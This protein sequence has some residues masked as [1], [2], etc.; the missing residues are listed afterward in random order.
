MARKVARAVLPLVVLAWATLVVL[1]G[2]LK[3]VDHGVATGEDPAAMTGIGL[4]AIVVALLLRTGVGPLRGAPRSSTE[5]AWRPGVLRPMR[6]AAYE[7]PPTAAPSP[8]LLQV[9][10]T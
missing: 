5:H 8:A 10:L 1:G 2:P 3:A 9:L 4:C 7:N 6:P